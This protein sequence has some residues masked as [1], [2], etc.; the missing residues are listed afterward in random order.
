MYLSRLTLNQG[1]LA[2]NWVANPY[3]VHQRL[4]IACDKDPRVLFR[5]ES[6]QTP[7]RILVQSWQEPDWLVVFASFDVLG[8][9]V[10]CKPFNPNFTPGAAYHFR[11]LANPTVKK[12]HPGDEQGKRIGLHKDENQIA[13]INRK[14]NSAGAQILTCHVNM[15]EMLRLEKGPSKDTAPLTH[16]AVLFEGIL[17][18]QDPPE[19]VEAIKR[20]IGPAKGF[21]F[22]L[23]SLA[24]A[25]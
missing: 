22:G 25:D 23:L 16:L 4:M 6:Q 18:V 11:I 13:W 24:R 8:M 17:V 3:R 9:P 7:I 19:L 21:G 1:R 10:E 2:M 5:I 20:G 14:L 15:N 12:S